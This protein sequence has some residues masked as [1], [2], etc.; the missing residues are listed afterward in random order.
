[1]SQ[2]TKSNNGLCEPC[3]LRP[4]ERNRYFDGKLL[5]TRDFQDEQD[6]LRGKDKLH[7]SLLHGYGTV[8]GLKVAEH[9]IRACQHRYVVL[10]PGLALDCCGREIIVAEE[11]KVDLL[12]KIEEALRDKGMEPE[13]GLEVPYVFVRLAYRQCDTDP[14]PALLDDCGCSQTDI[15]FSRTR[16]TYRLFVD[17]GE[18]LTEA[19]EPLD[20]RLDWQHT[21]SL[22]HPEAVVFDRALMR[23]YVAEY[24]GS[25]GHLRL[26]DAN[27]HSQITRVP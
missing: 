27:N 4:F 13:D 22:A 11:T 8:C 26:Y 6:Y 15:E 23:L 20:A 1:M 9:P 21:L 7:N 17:L 3:G 19:A 14:V 18:P 25:E 10:E 5:T 24:D 12:A 2:N 16:E